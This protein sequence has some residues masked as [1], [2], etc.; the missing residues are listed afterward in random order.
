[1]RELLLTRHAESEFNASGRIN[2]DPQI[3]CAL[4]ER[5]KKQAAA[6]EVLL[7]KEQIDLCVTSQHE[8]AI[9]TADAALDGRGIPRLVLAD[10]NEP[11]AGILEGGLASTYDE[12]LRSEGLGSPNPGGGESQLDALRRYVRA[13]RTLLQRDER[14][15]LVVAHGMPIRWL[16]SPAAPFDD[17]TDELSVGFSRPGVAFAG[18]PDRYRIDDLKVRLDALRQQLSEQVAKSADSEATA[19]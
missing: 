19:L 4:T 18:Q 16:R 2:A 7:D 12:R 5:G 6:L 3:P 10:L 8:R 11:N 1:M 14:I 13:Y 15:Q 17:S 9:A